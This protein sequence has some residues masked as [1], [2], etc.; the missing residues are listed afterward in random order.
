MSD[1]LNIFSIEYP[2]YVKKY[3]NGDSLSEEELQKVAD[4]FKQ[5]ANAG[6]AKAMYDYGVMLFAGLGVPENV[7]E[8]ARYFKITANQG[9][10]EAMFEYGKTLS[11]YLYEDNSKAAEYLKMSANK[12]HRDAMY[13]YGL[14]LKLEANSNE[15]IQE[16]AKYLK[17]AMDRGNKEAKS[18][19]DEI[20][21]NQEIINCSETLQNNQETVIHSETPEN[22]INSEITQLYNDYGGEEDG[23][24]PISREDRTSIENISNILQD[25]LTV[26]PDNYFR[27]KISKKLLCITDFKEFVMKEEYLNIIEYTMMLLTGK[28]I[29]KDFRGGLYYLSA[30][31]TVLNDYKENNG[32]RDI[33]EKFNNNF[34]NRIFEAS[35]EL[36]EREKIKINE[37]LNM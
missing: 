21:H 31:L 25:L 37:I 7:R 33:I 26:N 13:Y 5:S 22:N 6:D 18:E 11:F 17:M 14:Y 1:S 16:A 10:V 20:V 30:L 19:Y 32:D 24:D 4:Y 15:D 23:V 36:N 2:Q 34:Y 12:G 3:K 27:V 9:E 29:K 35:E 8:A 28:N